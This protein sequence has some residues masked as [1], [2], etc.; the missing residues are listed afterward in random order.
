MEIAIGVFVGAQFRL[1]RDL[2]GAVWDPLALV[3]S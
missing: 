2:S 3:A 1:P